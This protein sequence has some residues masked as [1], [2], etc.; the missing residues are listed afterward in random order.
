MFGIGGG[1]LIFIIIIALMLFG[2]DKIPDIARTLGKAMAQLKNA[3]NEIK[4]EI[5]KSADVNDADIKSIAGGFRNEMDEVKQ[6]FN[7]M[8][9][10]PEMDNSINIKSVT[11]E[12]TSEINSAKENIDDITGPIKRQK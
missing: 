10:D 2:A 12:I 9:S 6:G 11:N 3:T 8:I 7:K 5:T 4:T 1:E